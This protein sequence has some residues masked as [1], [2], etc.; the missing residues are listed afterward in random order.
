MSFKLGKLFKNRS[1]T[2]EGKHARRK[3]MELIFPDLIQNFEQLYETKDDCDLIIYAGEEPNIQKIYAH[4]VI[5][6]CQSTYFHT[7]FSNN[8]AER[9]DGMYI[10]YK[11]NVTPNI[12]NKLV[13]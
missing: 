8:W 11:P 7:A 5:L 10:F 9:K 1:F 6:R 13:K 12:M 3:S 2:N 4:S